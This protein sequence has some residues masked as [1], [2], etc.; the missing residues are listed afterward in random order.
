MSNKMIL[1]VSMGTDFEEEVDRTLD[2]LESQG[3][4][5]DM[6]KSNGIDC[7]QYSIE[8]NSAEGA[9]LFGKSR[10]QMKLA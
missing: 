1:T 2:F 10:P 3:L 5:I 4:I 8:F 7:K 9:F 6:K